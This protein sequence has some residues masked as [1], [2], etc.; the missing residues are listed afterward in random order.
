MRSEKSILWIL[1]LVIYFLGHTLIRTALGW[2]T[3]PDEATLITQATSY[4][5]LYDGE[6]PLYIWLQTAAFQYFGPTVFALALVKNAILLLIALCV[7][8][9][10]E[11]DASTEW[12]VAALISLLFIP[13]LAWTSQHS[14]TSPVL[15]T[16]GVA[17][18]FLSF[19]ALA[20]RASALGYLGLGIVIGLSAISET[21]YLWALGGLFLAALTSARYRAVLR[22]K[23]VLLTLITA[24]AIAAGPYMPILST[25]EVTDPAALLPDLNAALVIDRAYAIY[26]VL[27]NALAFTGLL[28]VGTSFAVYKGLGAR[29]E[30]PETAEALRDLLARSFSLG[31]LLIFA[32]VFLSGD[33][34]FSM[35]ALQPL[36]LLTGP[37]AALYIYPVIDTATYRTATN[38]AICAAVL[39]LVTTPAH[40]SFNQ[41]VQASETTHFAPEFISSG[42]PL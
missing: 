25:L 35:A 12:A 24:P 5:W 20:S 40:Y 21:C 7:F 14:L 2:Q 30:I 18:T 17:A 22:N 29:K 4:Q 37:I 41:G 13:Q 9:M 27:Q 15:A 31:L 38:L 39:I 34:S 8:W 6:M 33:A 28:I 10:V 36:M 19:T 23:W 26:D 32:Y 11:R 3:T 42:L 1:V 16:L